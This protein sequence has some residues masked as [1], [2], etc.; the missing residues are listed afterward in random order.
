MRIEIIGIDPKR[1]R[2]MGDRFFG[3]ILSAQNIS[4]VIVTAK[5]LKRGYLMIEVPITFRPRTEAEGKNL[6]FV[7]D[8]LTALY[9]LLKYRFRD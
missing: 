6:R 2:I 4:E 3:P 7:Q 8:G 9:T 1:L 5:L